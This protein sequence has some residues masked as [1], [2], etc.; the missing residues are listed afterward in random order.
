MQA[1]VYVSRTA[2]GLEK[3]RQALEEIEQELLPRVG[4]NG[5]KLHQNYSLLAY[6]DVEKMV[7]AAQMIVAAAQMRNES[8]G[9][10]Y[11]EEFPEPDTTSP[12]YCTVIKIDE[13]TLNMQAD[14]RPVD[15][16]E[17]HP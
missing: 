8:R 11:M 17:I 9:A 2:K 14:V 15:M 12:P 6:L 4:I 1:H 3:A 16:T 13:G 7:K 10:H 5:S